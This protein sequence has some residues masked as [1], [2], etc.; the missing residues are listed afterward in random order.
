LDEASEIIPS[1]TSSWQEEGVEKASLRKSDFEVAV[2]SLVAGNRIDCDVSK[3]IVRHTYN[4]SY[5]ILLG[6]FFSG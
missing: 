1:R 2:G 4:S 5:Y 3:I 6:F